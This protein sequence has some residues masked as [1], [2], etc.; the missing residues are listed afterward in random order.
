MADIR[1]KSNQSTHWTG[2]LSDGHI[3]G[4][5]MTS[6]YAHSSANAPE[7]KTLGYEEEI[8]AHVRRGGKIRE[9]ENTF[10]FRGMFGYFDFRRYNVSP[11]FFEKVVRPNLK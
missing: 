6:L 3:G 8:S 4:H 10:F 11:E 1:E 7:R 2:G 5:D 9:E